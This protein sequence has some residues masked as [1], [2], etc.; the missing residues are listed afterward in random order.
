MSKFEDGELNKSVEVDALI[1]DEEPK[2]KLAVGVAPA[3]PNVQ[4]KDERDKSG[5][6]DLLQSFPEMN[7]SELNQSTIHRINYVDR[8]ENC[9]EYKK[10]MMTLLGMGFTDF[11][12]NLKALQLAYNNLELAI[13]KLMN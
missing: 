6:P 12:A 8:L 7:I 2:D 1:A 13:D 5:Y 9:Q 10:N 3:D 4:I 11:N